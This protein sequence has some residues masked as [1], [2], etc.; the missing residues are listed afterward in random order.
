MG[1]EHIYIFGCDM[2]PD[3]LNGQLHF[4]GQNPDV[5]PKV[6]K[7]RF[8]KEAEFYDIAADILTPEQ[9]L[10][11]TFCS[12]YNPW[13]FVDKFNRRSHKEAIAH[14]LQHAARL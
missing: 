13:P 4:Y 7:E 5:D 3:G 8:A 10:R 6:R 2:N 12:E 14:I 9:R 11:F 1:H